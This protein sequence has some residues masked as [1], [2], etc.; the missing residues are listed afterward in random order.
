MSKSHLIL[1]ESDRIE[2]RALSKQNSLPVKIYKR[3]LY[4]LALDAGRTFQ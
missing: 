2:L 4:L 3:V 1:S